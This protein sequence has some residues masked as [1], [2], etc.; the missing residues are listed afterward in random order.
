MYRAAN[1]LTPGV[2]NQI[3]EVELPG[4]PFCL[5]PCSPL[6]RFCHV[7]CV[8]LVVFLAVSAATPAQTEEPPPATPQTTTELKPPSKWQWDLTLRNRTG[9]R[10]NKPR[11]FQMSR[12]YLDVKV[13]YKFSDHWKL[14]AEGRAM[15]DAVDRLGYPRNG[16]FE[17][18]QFLL[19][20]KIKTV[21]LSLGL[22]QTVWGQSD[23]LRVLDVV[24]PQDYRE[25]LL[26]DFLDSRRP[27]WTVRA[28]IPIKQSSLQ[29]IWIPYF[30]P[31]RL[32]GPGDEFGAG[33]S[34]GLGIINAG[35]TTTSPLP[36]PLKVQKAQRPPVSLTSS[37]FG[38]R[39][40]HSFGRWDVTANVFR[41]WEDIP[42]PYFG[43]LEFLPKPSIL[44]T[45]RF[46]RKTVLG[47]TAVTNF[48][49]VVL[50]MEAGWNF[51]KSTPVTDFPPQTGFRQHG[52]FSG[53]VGVDY[54]PRPW[55]WVSGQYFLQFTSAPQASLVL[56]RYNHLAS[57]YI[58][59]NFQRE[60][61]KP[62]LFILTGLNQHEYLIRPRL[63]R[64][65]GDHWSV[66]LGVDFLGGNPTNPFGF[67]RSR[68]RA[69]FEIKW[70]K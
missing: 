65:F 69:V 34:Y 36:F 43:G 9:F 7:V 25:F 23:G 19:D 14:T 68:D 41:G 11:V 31:G 67:F 26:E 51:Q 8:F 50:R 61:L 70:I 28:D 60:T 35:L 58:R 54:S 59:T 56:P 64:S 62:E 2:L 53:V 30:A 1:S 18:R 46:D 22:Q 37:Q 17:L 29:V 33:E 4:L 20:G 13:R 38:A 3:S 24:N 39:F 52:Q 21:S 16:W 57:V 27:L 40:S 47:G 49:P 6:L 15:Y 32:P 10:L 45:P 48:G 44:I 66:G 42:T 55:V 5:L 63:T 12:T